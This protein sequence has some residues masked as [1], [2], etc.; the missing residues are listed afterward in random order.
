[1]VIGFDTASPITAAVLDD[2]ISALKKKGATGYVNL[3]IK[4]ATPA[5]VSL[6]HSKGLPIA[7][8][9]ETTAE[10][11]LG[12]YNAGYVDAR[13]FLAMVTPNLG[14]MPPVSVAPAWTA[15]FD[16]TSVQQAIVLNYGK[17]WRAGMAGKLKATCY[18]NGATCQAAKAAGIVDYTWDAGGNGMRGTKVYRPEADQ[19]QDV[20]DEQ[21]LGLPISIDSDTATDPTLPWAWWPIGTTAGTTTNAP[22]V[23]TGGT[24]QPALNPM[25]DL[26]AQQAYLGIADDGRWGPQTE[27]AFAAYWTRA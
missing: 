22:A 9:W 5:L 7:L 1:M 25:G 16:V 27:A 18:T 8:I 17:G 14:A 19:N 21:G 12:G 26:K 20:G 2:F 10:R 15:D 24:T 23:V 6:I 3:Y 11:A 13:N 4:W